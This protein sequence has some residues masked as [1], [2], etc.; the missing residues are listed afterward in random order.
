MLTLT[1]ERECVCHAKVPKNGDPV[2]ARIEDDPVWVNWANR[3]ERAE[4][5]L[6]TLNK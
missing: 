1:G 4:K 6:S 3:K 2:K 5:V